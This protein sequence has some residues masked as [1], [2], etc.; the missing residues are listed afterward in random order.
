MNTVMTMQEAEESIQ[1]LREIFDVV[2]LLDAEVIENI[3]RK[4]DTEIQD[5]N[6]DHDHDQCFSFWRKDHPCENCV[7]LKAY[8]A[9]DKRVKMEFIDTALYQVI[10]KYVE[11]DGKPYVI[12]MIN[13]LDDELMLDS[14]G[15]DRLL[16][17]LSGY[18]DELYIDALTGISNRRYF[19]NQIKKMKALAGVAMIDL[20]DFKLYNDTFG[21]RVGDA[22][23]KTV[24]KMIRSC[25]R[26]SDILIR[27]G[28]D[29]FLLVM[30]DIAADI[31]TQKLRQICKKIRESKVPGYS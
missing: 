26:K 4:N 31:F 12:E 17:K 19:E 18:D 6:Q 21:H 20:D 8:K 22:V 7:S 11:I 5:Q 24:A 14:E 30:P 2:R 1:K 27:Y 15:R 29:E 3:N 28:G 25:I 16:R 10:A 13:C 9:K 23:L